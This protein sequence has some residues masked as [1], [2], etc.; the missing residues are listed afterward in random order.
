VSILLKKR[1]HFLP[2]CCSNGH[3]RYNHS[4]INADKFIGVVGGDVD[5][6]V[7]AFLFAYENGAITS[8]LK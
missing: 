7:D 8:I 2:A 4:N 3:Y 1:A 5:P 6:V